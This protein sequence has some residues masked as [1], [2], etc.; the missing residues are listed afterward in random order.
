MKTLIKYFVLGVLFQI[1]VVPLTILLG[2]GDLILV[3]YGIFYEILGALF[4]IPKQIGDEDDI[5]SLIILLCIPAIFYAAIF[6]V[7]FFSIKRL[8]RSYDL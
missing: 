8:K 4:P 1:L 5:I 7:L 6:S 3:A 2:I